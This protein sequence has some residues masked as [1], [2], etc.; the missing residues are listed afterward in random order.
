MRSIEVDTRNSNYDRSAST[1]GD[2]HDRVAIIGIGARGRLVGRHDP[3]RN[4]D[5]RD[6]IEFHTEVTGARVVAGRRRSM[7]AGGHFQLRTPIDGADTFPDLVM[8][9]KGLNNVSET[10]K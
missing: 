9:E 8:H 3:G 10:H 2:D 6:D 4:P 7:D 5:Q 1:L